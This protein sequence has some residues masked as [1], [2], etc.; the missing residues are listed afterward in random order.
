MDKHEKNNSQIEVEH[1]FQH[2]VYVKQMTF[3]K[4][5]NVYCGHHHYYDHV[6][7]V[8]KG[9][10]KV[11]FLEVKE[12]GLEEEEKEFVGPSMFVT[13]AYR[14]HE[15]TALEDDTCVCCIHAVRTADGEIFVPGDQHTP[16]KMREMKDKKQFQGY[17]TDLP[18]D[19]KKK[20]LERAMQ[21]D[22]LVPDSGSKL[23]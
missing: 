7:L 20:I 1:A 19:M 14:E 9:K 4:K 13:R 15:I 10:V 11:K 16:E 3:P 8:A 21:E 2:N 5:G 18:A 22:T 17:A 6:T 23:I 12:V